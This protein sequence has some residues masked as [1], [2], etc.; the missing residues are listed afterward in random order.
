MKETLGKKELIR[1]S[2]HPP[3]GTQNIGTITL[4]AR[5]VEIP[6]TVLGG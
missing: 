2:N 6:T 3:L 1:P 4:Y 5:C